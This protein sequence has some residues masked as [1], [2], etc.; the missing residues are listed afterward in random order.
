M[1]GLQRLGREAHTSRY[2]ADLKVGAKV[3]TIIIGQI[4]IVDVEHALGYND[5]HHVA[6]G[7]RSGRSHHM[8]PWVIQDILGQRFVSL[9]PC[10]SA[11]VV[12]LIEI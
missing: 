12:K 4:Y 9:L 2:Y 6:Y 11:A 7:A 5:A 8:T 10:P 3:V 1:K